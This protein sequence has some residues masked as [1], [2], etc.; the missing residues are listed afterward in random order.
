MTNTAKDRLIHA[1]PNVIQ[2]ELFARLSNCKE[3][4]DFSFFQ[5]G[6]V[7]EVLYVFISNKLVESNY[8][9]VLAKTQKNYVDTVKSF[10]VTT[11][12]NSDNFIKMEDD[13][14]LRY[15]ET[16]RK[17]SSLEKFQ[18]YLESLTEVKSLNTTIS[19][20]E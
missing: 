6:F 19:I 3:V 16:L 15:L 4:P 11:Q 7:R 12:I 18:L 8:Q 5:R 17:F 9:Q 2:K 10:A 20:N 13:E 1:L 14:L